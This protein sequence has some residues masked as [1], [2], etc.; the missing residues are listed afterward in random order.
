MYFGANL[1][2]R[3]LFLPLEEFELVCFSCSFF[4]VHLVTVYVGVL[5]AFFFFLEW[6]DWEK[7]ENSHI[8]SPVINIHM[9]SFFSNLYCGITQFEPWGLCAVVLSVRLYA[10]MHASICK[11]PLH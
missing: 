4:D 11:A 3:L 7:N 5:K 1:Q 9:L 2:L 8:S 10:P 6:R